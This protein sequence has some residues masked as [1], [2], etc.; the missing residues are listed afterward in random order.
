MI[1]SSSSREQINLVKV[2][3][4]T[5]MRDRQ[6]IGEQVTSWMA[7]NPGT[8]IVKRSVTQS[9]DDEFHC[10]SIVL[11]CSATVEPRRR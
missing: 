2:F 1:F 6:S 8:R 5:K 9:S 7:A 3:S 10:L 11:F 4:A